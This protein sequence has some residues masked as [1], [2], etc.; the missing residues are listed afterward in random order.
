MFLKNSG[1]YTTNYF[2]LVF[3]FEVVMDD[4]PLP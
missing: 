2:R 4:Q 1:F 3:I